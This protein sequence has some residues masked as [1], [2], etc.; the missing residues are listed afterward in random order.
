MSLYERASRTHMAVTR[1]FLNKFV[2]FGMRLMPMPHLPQCSYGHDRYCKVEVLWI[3]CEMGPRYV[4]NPIPV[5][6][7]YA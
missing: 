4:I 5:M 3:F 1:L 7:Q 6:S 2:N